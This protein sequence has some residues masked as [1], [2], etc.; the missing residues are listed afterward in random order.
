MEVSFTPLTLKNISDLTLHLH[1]CLFYQSIRGN[2]SDDNQDLERSVC[3][4]NVRSSA[5]A[6]LYLEPVFLVFERIIGG[7]RACELSAL[8]TIAHNRKSGIMMVVKV[9]HYIGT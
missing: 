5:F 1:P 4:G 7:C 2:I 9:V 8:G 6:F 3:F